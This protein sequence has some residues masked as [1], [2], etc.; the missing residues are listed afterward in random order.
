MGAGAALFLTV[1]IQF[2][3]GWELWNSMPSLLD[4]QVNPQP[5][6]LKPYP[7]SWIPK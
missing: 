5:Y 1:A 2:T 7:P 4:P 6:N 3:F